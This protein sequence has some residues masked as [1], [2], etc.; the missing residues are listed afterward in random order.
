MHVEQAKS[1]TCRCNASAYFFEKTIGNFL[2]THFFRLL[3]YLKP[4]KRLYMSASFYSALNKIFD[5]A[6]EILLGVAVD[7]IARQ[8]ASWISQLGITNI[9]SQLF[10]LG[11]ITFLIWVCE[12]LTEYIY[13]VKW[14]NLSQYLQHH[15]RL[16]AYSHI[17]NLDIAYFEDKSTGDLLS[18]LNDDVNQLE[19][20]FETGL[21][22][23]IQTFVAFTAISAV[24]FFLTPGVAFFAMTPIPFI[25][26][27]AF[28]FQRKLSPRYLD[29]R[30]K[31]GRIS[32]RLA[33][34]ISGMFTIKSFT[35]EAYERTQVEQESLAYQKAN[36]SAI[37]I[38]S[39]VTPVIR[40]GVL[41]GFLSTLL[42]GGYLTIEGQ[43]ELG[44]FSILLFLTQRL[45]WPLT[46]LAELTVLYQRA[47]ASA[48]RAMTLLAE[49][50]H[51]EKKGKHI[52]SVQGMIEFK[53]VC[54][55]YEEGYSILKNVSFKI[56]EGST[57]AFVGTTGSGKTTLIKLLLRFYEAN[58]GQIHLDG[59]LLDTL[60]LKNIRQNIGIVSQDVFLFHGSVA[61]NIAYAQPHLTE[62]EIIAAAKQAEAHDFIM[63]LPQGYKTIIGERGQKLS[64]GQRQRLAIA[65]AILKNPPILILDEATSAVDN[66][67]ELA[68]QR[69][70]EQI[71]KGRTT[72][73][74]AHRLSTVRQCDRIFVLQNGEITEEGTH[75]SL[76][77]LNQIYAALWKLQTGNHIEKEWLK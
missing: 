12:S 2:C 8:E 63:N 36:Q 44:S 57:A 56:P 73:M 22:Q 16:D 17:Q 50:I 31:A 60:D 5:I 4:K 7:V 68:I 74:I 26:I 43:L 58:A 18:I 70:L 46:G 32:A 62:E 13:S 66:E 45:L 6:P 59:Q 33:N 35:A 69:S 65:R 24:F 11:F 27:G 15:L 49:P 41:T 75:E 25:I 61:E 14:R 21:S 48:K 72:I 71:V 3:S 53:D 42:Y 54:F 19:R 52:D 77:D 40:I 20:F 9:Y 76:V 23:M 37:A 64:G 39:M 1:A 29:V 55:S 10:F 51:I 30:E 34:N 47:M 28:Y 67:T 38:S